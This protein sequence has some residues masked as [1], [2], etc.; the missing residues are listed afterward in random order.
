M[1]GNIMM[2][3]VE[4][5]LVGCYS[6]VIV[7]VARGLL[8]KCE[9]KYSYYLWFIVFLNLSLPFA[10]ESPF[11]LIPRSLAEF[12]LEEDLAGSVGNRDW[13]AGDIKGGQEMQEGDSYSVQAGQYQDSESAGLSAT[14]YG[15]EEQSWPVQKNGDKEIADNE[16]PGQEVSGRERADKETAYSD[17][18]YPETL[19]AGIIEKE[20]SDRNISDRNTSDKIISNFKNLNRRSS[21]QAIA[22]PVW[23][24]GIAVILSI[25]AA[26]YLRLKLRIRKGRIL[27]QD[28]ENRIKVVDS[29]Q[30][31]F[32]CGMIRPWVYLPAGMTEEEKAYI[33]AHE[34]YH[35]R[36][37]DYLLKAAALCITAVHWF[38]PFAWLALLLFCQDMEVSCDEKVLE[39]T[40]GQVRKQY[41]AS[42]LKFAAMQNGFLVT[43]LNFGKPALESRIKNVLKE[44][45]KSILIT[46][47]AVIGVVAVAMGLFLR[48]MSERTAEN[49]ENTSLS[50][51]EA[52]IGSALN[53][54]TA[55][56]STEGFDRPE[57]SGGVEDP[58]GTEGSGGTEG[59]DGTEGPGNQT[60]SEDNQQNVQ[61]LDLSKAIEI[62][63]NE[64]ATEMSML[65]KEV[66]SLTGNEELVDEE[67][68]IYSGISE[69]AMN[70]EY[71]FY[72]KG[73]Y[74]LMAQYDFMSEIYSYNLEWDKA[75]SPH[76]SAMQ[77]EPK[78]LYK[79]AE[80]VSLIELQANDR[81][82]YWVEDD[83]ENG[84]TKVC[85]YELETGDFTCIAVSQWGPSLSI[86]NKYVTWYDHLDDGSDEIVIYDI[87]AQSFKKITAR[88]PGEI[89]SGARVDLTENGIAYFSRDEEG[90]I[91]VNRYDLDTEEIFTLPL[92]PERASERLTNCFSN[93]DYIVWSKRKAGQ[94]DGRAAYYFYNM[95]SGDLYQWNE[96]GEMYA[97][98][99]CTSRFLCVLDSENERIFVYDFLNK[100]TCYQDMDEE[101]SFLPWPKKQDENVY[102]ESRSNNEIKLYSV[103]FVYACTDSISQGESPWENEQ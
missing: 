27:S 13:D 48:P 44:K 59:P 54:G 42:L 18:F 94:A 68:E 15:K 56:G 76:Q 103:D 96:S 91:Y 57:G 22:G 40:S 17:N 30:T 36:R 7:L 62:S 83:H 97:T 70:G 92:G 39:H 95:K 46:V 61:F 12:S 55:S 10:V 65:L 60:S 24:L 88:V 52:G 37:R 34:Q 25:N 73:Y 66:F 99:K 64:N 93:S 67:N 11:S 29:L 86:S 63:L 98:C 41:A 8:W 80:G 82:L 69:C 90:N 45:K 81:Y 72:V 2:K 89:L 26:G 85:Q 38:N 101:A 16:I 102:F 47:A 3:V 9:R 31:A 58:D 33:T 4:M 53:G 77:Q 1:L 74:K 51:D 87:E 35:R 71:A 79:T 75:L 14:G 43:S 78:L 20:I 6:V 5:S 23:I 32:V 50:D 19:D 100:Q 49:G 28:S 84:Q 21:F